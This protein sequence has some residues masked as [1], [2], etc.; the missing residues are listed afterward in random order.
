M[1]VYS[2][3]LLRKDRRPDFSPHITLRKAEYR[4]PAECDSF[5]AEINEYLTED[6]GMRGK[7]EFWCTGI[8]LWQNKS[9]HADLIDEFSFNDVS[10]AEDEDDEE[11]EGEY[12]DR[13]DED[14]GANAEF[15]EDE[16][17]EEEEYAEEGSGWEL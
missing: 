5:R 4:D 11:G 14:S 6:W 7:L 1:T 15:W 3:P 16:Q 10:D 8:E 2:L 9:W 12:S 13:E 17:Y